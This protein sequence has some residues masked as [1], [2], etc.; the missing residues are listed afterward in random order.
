MTTATQL[1]DEL[2]Y[3]WVNLEGGRFAT[4]KTAVIPRRFQRHIAGNWLLTPYEFADGSVVIVHTGWIPEGRPELEGEAPR[5]ATGIVVTPFEFTEDVLARA[6]PDFSFEGKPRLGELD[7]G[8]LYMRMQATTPPRDATYVVLA[9]QRAP[10]SRPP[11]VAPVDE[12]EYPQPATEYIL[13][14]YLTPS[15]HLGYA[16]LWYGSLLMLCWIFYAGWTGRLDPGRKEA[17]S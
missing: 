10:L 15:I 6:A 3:R 17:G 8:S 16:A 11:A 12:R 4:D 14:P 5:L 1:T 9:E 7:P 2:D 13:N